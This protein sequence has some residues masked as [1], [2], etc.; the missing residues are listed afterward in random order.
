MR[1]IVG[2]RIYPSQV[3]NKEIREFSKSNISEE[4]SIVFFVFL[5]REHTG[6]IQVLDENKE[7]TLSNSCLLC[8]RRIS[9]RKGAHGHVREV[10]NCFIGQLRIGQ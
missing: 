2:P 9:L 5:A 1:R 6:K 7:M 4:G 3:V 8:S 10:S